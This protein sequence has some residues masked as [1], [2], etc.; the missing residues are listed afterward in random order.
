LALRGADLELPE[1]HRVPVTWIRENAC[2]SIKWRTVRDI[3]P[4][5]SATDADVAELRS[6]LLDYKPVKQ[7]SKKQWA[8]GTWSGNILGIAPSKVQG[9]RDAGAVTQYRRLVEMGV[10]TNARPFK[11]AD[12]LFYRIL[13][14]D[15]DPALLFEMKQAASTNPELATWYRDLMREGVTAALAQAGNGDDPRVRGAANRT[16]TKVSRFLRGELADKPIVRKGSR[17]VLDREAYPPTVFSV[18]TM[19][20]LPGLQRERAGFVERLSAYVVKSAPKK[21][22]TIQIGRKVIKPTFH[23]LGDPI[24]ADGSGRAKD[25]PFAL[26][27]MELLARLGVFS[28]SATTQKV[29]ARLLKDCDDAGVWNPGNLRTLPK[30][31]SGLA[32]FACP[33]EQDTKAVEARKA[34][35]SFRLALIARLLGLRLEY[36]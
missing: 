6:E 30:G 13:S 34:D 27:W 18:A 19:A 31:Q 7:I 33:L 11:L 24:Q 26:H 2:P 20:Y 36:C 28:E 29:F 15:Q 12:R 25:L 9:I 8:N 32:D 22:Y 35:I 14:R 3:L 5:G 16:F 4:P 21:T 17:N 1:S 23:V 10:P